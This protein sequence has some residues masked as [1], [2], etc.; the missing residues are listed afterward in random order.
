[1]RLLAVALLMAAVAWSSEPAT[2]T[3]N[4]GTM[5]MREDAYRSSVRRLVGQDDEICRVWLREGTEPLTAYQNKTTAGAN[6]SD[7][8]LALAILAQECF[9]LR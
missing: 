5:T 3:L 9:A 4:L 6:A 2:R 7:V 8:Q 1:M